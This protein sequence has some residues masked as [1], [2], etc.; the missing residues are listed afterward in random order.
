VEGVGEILGAVGR[1]VELVVLKLV[2]DGLGHDH[3]TGMAFRTK[4]AEL[5]AEWGD[6][7]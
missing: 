2:Y 7:P 3:H 6:I 1:D 5:K 4:K